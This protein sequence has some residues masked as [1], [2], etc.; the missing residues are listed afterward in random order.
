M[1]LYNDQL[2]QQ[3]DGVAMGSPLGS[4]LANWF[5]GRIEEK[6]FA[7][8]VDILPKFYCRYVDDSF[9]IVDCKSKC[10]AFF[11]LLNN[12]HKCVRF[13]VEPNL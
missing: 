8:P 3:I 10:D 1:F 11:N 7:L 12:Q 5:M 4:T 6:I 2:F 13:T 9:A